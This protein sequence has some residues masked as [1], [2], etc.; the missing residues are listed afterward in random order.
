MATPFAFIPNRLTVAHRF[1]LNVFPLNVLFAS[2]RTV[3]GREVYVSALYA[4]DL[5]SYWT[6]TA[7]PA[8][9]K[10]HRMWYSN[11]YDRDW[12][13]EIIYHEQNRNYRAVKLHRDKRVFM[14]SG[15]DWQS[16]FIS[17]TGRG[18]EER[19]GCRERF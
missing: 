4:P 15:K 3:R 9:G 5:S 14:V 1:E 18:V 2:K 10:L 11:K 13:L 8:G 12:R 6:C 19:E 16:F 17:L 7:S